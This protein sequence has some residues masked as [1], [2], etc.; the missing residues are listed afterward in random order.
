MMRL[1]HQVQNRIFARGWL[2]KTHLGGAAVLRRPK[3]GKAAALPYHRLRSLG[4]KQKFSLHEPAV[5][6]AFLLASLIFPALPAAAQSIYTE[7]YTFTTFAGPD[8]S[9]N[10]DGVGT[11]AQFDQPQSV[12]VDTNGN[13]YV[14]DTYNDTIR[15]ITPE[16]VVTTFAGTPR[17]IGTNDGTGSAAQF[18]NPYGVAV[19]TNGNVYVADTYNST[20]RKITPEGV[21]TTLAGNPA[22]TNKYGAV[23]GY[24][25]G[26]GSNALFY[27][28]EGVAVDTNGNVYVA[29]TENYVIRKVTPEGVVTTLAGYA[30]DY[31]SLNGTGTGARFGSPAGVAV[32][33]TGHVYVA[34]TGNS[35]IRRVGPEG[36]TTT[37]AGNAGDVGVADGTGSAAQ[38]DEPFGVAVDS[39]GNVYVGDTYSD[40]IRMVTPAGVVTTLAGMP[41]PPP[42]GYSFVPDYGLGG[43]VNGTGDSAQ[44][45]EPS[46]VAVDSAG[47]VYVADTANNTIRMVTSVG[48][49]TTL[50][51][52]PR[53]G[54][55]DG[56]G[57]EARFDY[58]QGIAVGANGD[59]YVADTDNDTIRRI[60]QAAV[61]STLAGME[62]STGYN[63]GPG[64]E[65][66][67][68]QPNSLAVDLA[69]NVYVADTGNSVIRMV[70]P[71]G[72][73]TTL[74]GSAQNPGT[75]DGTGINAQFDS[76][77]G[78]AVDSATNVYVADME[79][80]TIRK[81]T[82]VGGN[83]VVTTLA[84]QAGHFPPGFA[85]GTGSAARFSYPAGVAVDTNGNV[86]VADSGNEAI[87]KVTPA[88]VVTT[89]A[90]QAGYSGSNDGTGTNAQ[91]FYP[92]SVAVDSAGNVYVADTD[93]DTIRKV[94]PA[95]VVTTLA[96]MVGVN[97]DFDGTGALALFDVPS[98][99]AVDS[100][101]NIYV[102]DRNNCSIRKGV[103]QAF[104][105]ASPGPF[106]P[107]TNNAT[108]VV[109]LLPP[110]ANGQWRFPWELAWRNSGEAVNN[111]AQGEYPVEFSAV[112]GY[113]ILPF[114]GL[115]NNGTIVTNL[116]A[117]T[118]GGTTFV[119]NQYYPTIGTVDSTN[120]GS[121]T[122]N[123]GPS[124]PS[125]AG[126]RFLESTNSFFPPGFSTN[127]LGGTYLIQFAPVAGF[128][129]PA[130]LSVQI[131]PGIP[132]ALAI[133][134]LLAQAAPAGLL[135]PVPVPASNISD[136]TNWPYGFNGQLQTDVGYGSGVAV[137]TNV[138]LTAA[139]L[140]FNDQ[141]LSY[142]GH[143]YW[144]YQQEA[145]VSAP[146][147]LPA[148]GWFVL[149]GYAAA[150]TNDVLGGLGPDQSSPQSRNFDVAA[151]Y[152][153]NPVANGGSGGYLPSDA[154]PNLWLT[155][156]AEKMLV[157]Y[158]VDGSQFDV[159]NIVNG[160][161]YE[162]GPQPYPLT[163]A[164]DPIADQQVYTAS[165]FL[166]YPGNSGGPFYVQLNG[167]YYPAGVYLGTL[168]NG[169]VPYASAVRAIDSNVVNMITNAQAFVVSGTNNSG[170]GI[171][172]V[173]AGAGVASNPGIVVMTIAPPAAVQAGA[174]W[175]LST[176]PDAD[177]ST[178][179]PSALSVTSAGA[180]QLQFKQIAGWN[181][182]VSQSV[183]VGAGS[184][185]SVAGSY[186]VAVAWA[187]P[188]AITYGTALGS[189]QLDAVVTIAAGTNSYNPPAG[190][191]L[192]PGTHTLS[193]TFTPSDPADYGGPSTTNVSLTVLSA[194]PSAPV[195][196][197]A[198]RS[199]SS[200]TF[201][202]N[203]TSNQM[204][205]IQSTTNLSKANWID[206]GGVIPATNS[207]MSTS[208]TIATN[209]Q[210]FY[211]VVLL[212]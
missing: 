151:L 116:V 178:R 15:K 46:G 84:G 78:V 6:F 166:S 139:H 102:A 44:F 165:W 126:W 22:R 194:G 200:F 159:S 211:R 131:V 149:S 51:G 106:T 87:R 37:L 99:V 175:K 196:Q 195:L 70:T 73:V 183:A 197:A 79:N 118:N 76:P 160:Q 170:G 202:W 141:T 119:T 72:E 26:T 117:V 91:F 12:A 169:V 32:D 179:N 133:T 47:N 16:G 143:A 14:A 67:F 82:L 173:S 61:V 115:A 129:T 208:E 207:T 121:L 124:P 90:G 145:G 137:G 154:T 184:A 50:A 42:P 43:Y 171:I 164:P 127:V 30:G 114:V 96:G 9:R 74:A 104:T 49:V 86:Y 111:L 10:A 167:Y 58:L 152:F 56:T 75:N 100:A 11:D 28:P 144:F 122:V 88:G 92:S 147:P 68:D 172:N 34:D 1:N 210:Q 107:S 85:D 120:G 157:G 39:E 80:C 21:V 203:A 17:S 110:E 63:D 25:D 23:A 206:L 98:G 2:M 54:S 113:L 64:T 177:Y 132:T 31:G 187:T 174:A 40:T 53:S 7:A 109:T 38:F 4:Q 146:D 81:M 142:V 161:M 135:L 62:L 212:L 93:N 71:A 123:I 18:N 125:G 138:V 89:L 180:V 36:N 199:G 101:G 201:T 105:A 83:W 60:T 94:T 128:T 162:V 65:A 29:D 24:V 59:V 69:G 190:T 158:P 41:E 45:Y 27:Y 205:R 8:S 136:L 198:Q 192:S 5:L 204:Y 57:T 108:L 66:L 186:T 103:F 185:V 209:S 189:Q 163:L 155:S 35:T 55:A 3:W 97:R 134:Y 13:V 188:A 130:T 20:I 156:M 148:R 140:V 112:P 95:G 77:E 181:L 33:S 19:D 153:Q 52:T 176:L 48:L 168:F 193:V 182:P 150:R 191:V